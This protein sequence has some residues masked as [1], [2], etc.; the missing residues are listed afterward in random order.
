[1]DKLFDRL[2]K[3]NR[4]KINASYALGNFF[5]GGSV[6]FE[7]YDKFNMEFENVYLDRDMKIIIGK[8]SKC[9]EYN[10]TRK[11]MDTFIHR[12]F[13]KEKL[14]NIMLGII[15]GASV[16][17]IDID[18]DSF[19]KLETICIGWKSIEVK[20]LKM[21]E[22]SFGFNIL[23]SSAEVISTENNLFEMNEIVDVEPKQ[24]T[25]FE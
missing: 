11:D 8:D 21:F 22:P 6:K 15:S 24:L 2:V 16:T 25:L 5:Y 18:K 1:M 23:S 17:G 3:I 13:S 20:G 14:Y 7:I 4:L 12:R 19:D 10:I 9:V